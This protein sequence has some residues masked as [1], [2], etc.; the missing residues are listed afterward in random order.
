MLK[1]F[2]LE[3]CSA[4]GTTATVNLAGAPTGRNTFASKFST[5]VN[6]YYFMDDGTQWEA[7]WGVFTTGSPNTLNRGTVLANSAGTT[8]KLNFAG[9]TRIYNSLPA[10]RVPW[11]DQSGNLTIAGSATVGAGGSFLASTGGNGYQKL[12]SGLIRQ[13]GSST[14]GIG[15]GVTVTYPIVFP[16]SCSGVQLT[17]VN[18]GGAPTAVLAVTA[19]NATNFGVNSATASTGAFLNSVA[20]YWE[21]VGI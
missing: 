9:S 4:P 14:T 5:G 11:L 19:V 15:T 12:P 7:G 16:G 2:V 21:A 18:A 8:V 20:F 17:A 10:A 1:D 6:V 13:W 3:T